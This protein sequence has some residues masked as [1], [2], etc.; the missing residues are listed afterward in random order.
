MKP[1]IPNGTPAIQIL[2]FSAQWLEESWDFPVNKKV[3]V[4]IPYIFHGLNPE[5]VLRKTALLNM[6]KVHGNSHFPIVST[7]NLGDHYSLPTFAFSKE[8]ML[9]VIW[10]LKMEVFDYARRIQVHPKK[11]NTPSI[12]TL[13]WWHFPYTFCDF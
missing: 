13:F 5:K 12:N 4:K 11:G 1:H 7:S 10:S 6:V 9:N 8:T 3:D 2:H